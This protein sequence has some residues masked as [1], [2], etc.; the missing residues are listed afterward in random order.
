MDLADK[1]GS[2]V[3]CGHT[4]LYSVAWHQFKRRLKEV[5]S[6]YAVAGG[7]CKIEP[8]IDWGSH[9][10]AMCL[11]IGFDPA[12]ATIITAQDEMPLLFE[13]NGLTFR[14]EA[15][16]PSPLENLL[17]AFID[18]IEDGVPDFASLRLGAK[19]VEFLNEPERA[20]A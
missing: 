7:Q 19:V 5:T 20:A 3:Y 10:V 8:R 9:L 12:R 18:A 6:V 13:V 11:D 1:L 17:N 15:E 16:S 14:D 4:R 2:I